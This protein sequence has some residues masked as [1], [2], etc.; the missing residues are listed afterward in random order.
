LFDFDTAFAV[1]EELDLNPDSPKVRYYAPQR[2]RQSPGFFRKSLGRPLFVG[3]L[4]A[5]PIG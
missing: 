1:G 4:A 3:K 5:E 2:I